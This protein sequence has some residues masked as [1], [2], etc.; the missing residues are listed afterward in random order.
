MRVHN[1]RPLALKQ[2]FVEHIEIKVFKTELPAGTITEFFVIPNLLEYFVNLIMD[3]IW[4]IVQI[5]WDRET[6]W[7]PRFS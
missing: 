6:L 3:G 1:Q 2:V 4:D 7:T 5:P